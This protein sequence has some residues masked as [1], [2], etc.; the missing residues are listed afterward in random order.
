MWTIFHR[1]SRRGTNKAILIPTNHKKA[2]FNPCGRHSWEQ[3]L[4]GGVPLL[5]S[6]SRGKSVRVLRSL[7]YEH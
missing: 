7:L 1:L 2:L 5:A 3:Q 4:G 6:A